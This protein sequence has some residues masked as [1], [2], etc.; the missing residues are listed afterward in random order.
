MV[1]VL[2]LDRAR[3][4]AARDGGLAV[5]ITYC[6]DG[7]AAASVVNAGIVSHPVTGEPAVGYAIQGAARKKL[8]NL[9]ARRQS[10]VIFRSGWDWVAIEGE[11]DLVGPDDSLAG[12]EG[13][14]VIGVFHEIYV[15][16]IGGTLD[17]WASRDAAI[18]LER[19][20]AVPVRPRLVYSNAPA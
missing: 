3:E 17:D 16:A 6:A 13:D 15:A 9:R 5:V 10:T 8:A 4:L 14:E 11:V 19:H 18:T 2:L 12:I 7:A 1:D 20:A